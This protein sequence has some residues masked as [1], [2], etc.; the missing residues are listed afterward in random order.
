MTE[1]IRSVQYGH[2][3]IAT[4]GRELDHKLAALLDRLGP[5]V[6]PDLTPHRSRRQPRLAS[7]CLAPYHSTRGLSRSPCSSSIAATT[8]STVSCSCTTRLKSRR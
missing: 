2:P 5:P 3:E 8:P 6:P 4:V 1:A 7:A